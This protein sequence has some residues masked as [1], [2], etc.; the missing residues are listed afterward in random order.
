MTLLCS[1]RTALSVLGA[2]AVVPVLAAC[3]SNSATSTSSASAA[4][5]ASSAAGA[6]TD[7]ATD[8]TVAADGTVPTTIPDGMGSGEGDDVFPRTVTHFLGD[9]T[10]EAAPARLVIISTGQL[11][12]AVTLG[13]VPVGATSG[14]GAGTVPDYLPKLFPDDAEALAAITD[15]GSRTEPSVEEIAN[16]NP[17]LILMNISGKDAESLYS[18]LSQ[19]APTVATQGT[20]QYWK[21]DFLLLADALGKP[22]TAQTWLDTFHSDAAA[23]GEGIADDVTVSLLR[24]NGDRTRIFGAISFAGSVLADMGVARPDTQTF[25][26]DTSVDISEEELDQAD[27]DWILYGVQGG[28]ATELTDMSLWETLTAVAADQAVQ[29]EDDPFYLNAGPTAARFVMDTVSETVK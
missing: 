14:D 1:R 8:A 25:T 16:L 7:A 5:E 20:G 3:S 24:K 26:D 22:D 12:A 10:I 18:S 21:Q 15:V 17:D 13:V 2:A 4:S 19:I 29:V 6:A 23:A 9:T 11:D 27:G 28:D